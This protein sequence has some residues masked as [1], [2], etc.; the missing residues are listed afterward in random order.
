MIIEVIDMERQIKRIEQDEVSENARGSSCAFC[1]E[2]KASI[3]IEDSRSAEIWICLRCDRLIDWQEPKSKAR[4]SM[5]NEEGNRMIIKYVR[6]VT[7]K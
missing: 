7:W 5:C 2:L 6:E 4:R 1:K 3:R